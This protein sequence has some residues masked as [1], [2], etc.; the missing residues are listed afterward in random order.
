MEENTKDTFHRKANVATMHMDPY[1]SDNVHYDKATELS[2]FMGQ[3]DVDMVQYTL[4]CNKAMQD[5]KPRPKARLWRPPARP[6]L[7]INDPAWSL[8]SPEFKP[9]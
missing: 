6:E 3:Q 5:G 9:A 4:E 2:A 1:S 8:L 7:Q